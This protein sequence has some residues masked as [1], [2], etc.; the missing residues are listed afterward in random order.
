MAYE[1][2]RTV[3]TSIVWYFD[4]KLV[5]CLMFG[6]VKMKWKS[7]TEVD[8]GLGIAGRWKR[9]KILLIYLYVVSP[10]E[11]YDRPFRRC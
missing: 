8:L 5:P 6:N 2:W 11:N 3:E 1:G 7:I 4:V 9:S 10:C